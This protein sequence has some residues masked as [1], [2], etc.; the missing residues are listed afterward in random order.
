[1][2]GSSQA[3]RTAIQVKEGRSIENAVNLAN[4]MEKDISS[5][6]RDVVLLKSLINAL[7]KSFRRAQERKVFLQ[8]LFYRE[9]TLG[10]ALNPPPPR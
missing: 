10:Q 4:R 3:L 8:H 9:G 1:M 7:V 6:A 2:Q 5:M